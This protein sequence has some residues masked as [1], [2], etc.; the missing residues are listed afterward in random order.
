LKGLDVIKIGIVGLG[1]LGQIH[2]EH[3][4]SIPG[5]EVVAL[6]DINI[7]LAKKVSDSLNLPFHSFYD[8]FLDVCEAVLIATPTS[9]HFEYAELAIRKGK[10]VFIEKP[11]THVLEEAKKLIE[12]ADEAG[13]I[14]QV[15]HVERFNPAFTAIKKRAISPMFIESHRLAQFNVRGTDVSVV[16]DLMIHDIDIILSL[17]KANVRKVHA[18]GVA[19]ASDSIDIANARIEFDNGAVA[20]LTASRIS[21]KQ[22]R[23]MRL[24][25]HNEY[26]SI[27]FLDKKV[28]V[29]KLTDDPEAFGIPLNEAQPDKKI[30]MEQILVTEANAIK[31][32]LIAFQ[33][34]ILSGI[35]PETDAHEATKALELAQ[36]ILYQIKRHYQ[37]S[38]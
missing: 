19:V 15:G 13:V 16:L 8:A 11:I 33:N 4:T 5:F 27:D 26:I 14:V 31:E 24:F 21:F 22:M 17:V 30:Q 32:E 2:L 20:N 38:E 36:K 23:K 7:G 34:A 37:L 28:D 9:S 25:Q 6:Y 1:K 29:F 35:S 3:L 12:L 18:S 10:H